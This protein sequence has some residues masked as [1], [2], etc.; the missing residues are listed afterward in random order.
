MATKRWTDCEN[1]HRRDFLKVGTAGL[2][3][4]TLPELLRLEAQSVSSNRKATSVIMIWLA[5][6]PAT[7]DMWDLKPD[8]PEGIRGEFKPIDS[9]AAGVKIGEHLP[10]MAKVMNQCTLVRSLYHNIAAHELG[11][12][13]MTTGNKPT[14]AMQYPSLGSLS[15]KLLK[16]EPGVPPYVVFGGLRAGR[17]GGGGYLGTAYNP[18]EVEGDGGKGQLRVRGVSLPAGFSLDDLENRNRL[19]EAFDSEFKALDQSADITS[20]LDRFQEQALEILRSDK[21]K[22][23]F[24]LNKEP[25]ALRAQYGQTPFGQ[26]V[27]AARRLIEA[28]V[29]FA[30]VSLSGW[31]TH[32]GNFTTLKQRLLPQLDQT[33][34]A[35]IADLAEKGLLESTVV[36]CAGE[37]GRTPKVNPRAGRDHWGRSM[38]VILAGGGFKKGYCHGGTDAN[39]MAPATDPCLPDDV[40]ATIFQLLGLNPHQELMTPSGRPIALFREGKLINALLA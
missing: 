38:S 23:A 2:L 4:L 29:R 7:I 27:L 19:L 18:F 34:A 26:G 13:Y 24:D 20:G 31:D 28:G 11:T 5:G 17:A 3:G 8:A 14:P 39:G 40:S 37:F 16:S 30:T 35:L 32:N 36:Y 25:E 9:S 15:A 21:T 10:K 33:L 12:V 1:F 22:K 6:G